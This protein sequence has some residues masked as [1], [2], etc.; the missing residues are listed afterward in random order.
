MD[1]SELILK[2]I[3][4]S[5][6]INFYVANEN[7]KRIFF[8]VTDENNEIDD[9]QELQESNIYSNIEELFEETLKQYPIFMLNP[10][11]IHEDFKNSI[12]EILNNYA[13]R[14][15]IMLKSWKKALE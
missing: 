10:V 15:G 4:E 6:A 1:K 11:F 12:C 2:V 13:I 8:L 14:K 5:E 9:I 7:G 3:T